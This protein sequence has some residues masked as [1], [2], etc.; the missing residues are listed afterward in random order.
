MIPR[1]T[2]KAHFLPWSSAIDETPSPARYPLSRAAR[3]GMI[4]Y[5]ATLISPGVY[6]DFC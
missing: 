5:C 6:P 1:R 3:D 4:K 2:L